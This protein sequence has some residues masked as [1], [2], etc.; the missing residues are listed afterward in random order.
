MPQ[1]S[2]ALKARLNNVSAANNILQKRKADD[3]EKASHDDQGFSFAVN[4]IDYATE[5]S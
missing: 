3:H 5:E 2:K 1:K 4:N